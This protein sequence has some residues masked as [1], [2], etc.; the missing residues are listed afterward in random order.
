[1]L[2]LV[3]ILIGEFL[4]MFCIRNACLHTNFVLG[5]ERCGIRNTH[6][7]LLLLCFCKFICLFS[8]VIN[9]RNVAS[10]K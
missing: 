3:P 1:M 9:D 5:S 2:V 4:V 6:P 10:V 7:A 8:L